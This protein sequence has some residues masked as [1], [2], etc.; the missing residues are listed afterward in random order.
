MSWFA[1]LV[2][3]KIVGI[4]AQRMLSLPGIYWTLRRILWP[5]LGLRMEKWNGN[6]LI[7]KDPILLS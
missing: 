1:T 2:G 5:D 3:I 7:V 4:A 6:V